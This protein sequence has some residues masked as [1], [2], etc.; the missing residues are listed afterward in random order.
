M[1]IAFKTIFLTF[2]WVILREDFTLPTIAIGVIISIGCIAYS[3]KFLPLSEVKNVRFF[4]LFLYLFYLIWQIYLS[5]F[6]VIKLII[7]GKAR[8]D[9]VTVQT[10]LTNESLRVVLADSITLTPGSILLDL[11]DDK[12]TVVLMVGTDES[13]LTGSLA[14]REIKGSLEERLLK[15][16]R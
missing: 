1:G 12:I 2:I 16:Q 14:D 6:H 8:P 13:P 5:G 10:K 4:R 7:T 3:R 15:A 11:T 9:F